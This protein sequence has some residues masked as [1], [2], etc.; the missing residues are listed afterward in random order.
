MSG[1]YRESPEGARYVYLACRAD[2]AAALLRRGGGL[3]PGALAIGATLTKGYT[4]LRPRSGL[5]LHAARQRRPALEV[6]GQKVLPAGD[7]EDR[8]QLDIGEILR[9]LG[10]EEPTSQR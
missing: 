4:R 8:E 6:S 1:P 3:F 9:W 7:A 10:V 2:D 5:A